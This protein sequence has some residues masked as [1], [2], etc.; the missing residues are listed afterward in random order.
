ML[1]KKTRILIIDDFT[2]RGWVL[3]RILNS[4]GYCAN[5]LTYPQNGLDGI[6]EKRLDL[7][8][9]DLNFSEASIIR[10]L[11]KIKEIKPSLPIFICSNSVTEQFKDQ[12][13][14]LGVS[15]FFPK[16][17]VDQILDQIKKLS[18]NNKERELATPCMSKKRRKK[19]GEKRW[20]SKR[21][22]DLPA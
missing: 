4:N 14:E 5:S 7:L 12:A 15:I 10:I 8:I 1:Q 17:D 11:Q 19:G 21:T 2:E 9:F 6:K 20:Q 22:S 18:V 3:S 16:G 13:T